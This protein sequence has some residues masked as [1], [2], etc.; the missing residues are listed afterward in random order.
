MGGGLQVVKITEVVAANG[1]KG[2]Y[3]F[4][5]GTLSVKAGDMVTFINQTDE[6]HT[7]MS[8]PAG[9]VAD[10]NMI[11]KNETQVVRFLQAGSFT[12]SSVEHPDARLAVTVGSASAALAPLAQVKITEVVAT[13]GGKDQYSFSPTTVTV[14]NATLVFVNQTDEDHT[15]MS[16]VNGGFADGTV[17][18]KNETQVI[19]FSK[20]GTYTISSMEHPDAK[21]TV[22]VK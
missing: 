11:S 1:G 22:I 10:G 16:N 18:S 17:I 6:A 14:D 20:D 8:T 7:L 13:N 19:H 3:S 4:T 5:P 9:S 15:L 2:Q 12:I 21:L